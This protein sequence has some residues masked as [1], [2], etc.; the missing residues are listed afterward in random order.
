MVLHYVMVGNHCSTDLSCLNV[1]GYVE[2]GEFRAERPGIKKVGT[3]AGVFCPVVL[4]MF[5]AL[6]F[7]RMGKWYACKYVQLRS[8]DKTAA[9]Y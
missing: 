6:I 5:S 4:S 8:V 2:F 7:I 9:G 3:F 1:A